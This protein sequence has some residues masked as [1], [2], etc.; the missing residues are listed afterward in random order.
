MYNKHFPSPN[1]ITA[2]HFPGGRGVRIDSHVYTEYEIPP[3]YDSMITKIIATA[4]TREEAIAKMHQALS[5]T[6]IEGIKTTI[7][8]HKTMM[9]NPDFI[10]GD[11][12]TK[13]LDRYNWLEHKV[14]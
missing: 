6:V 4:W 14:D 8:F 9:K 2:L 10:K 13:Y 5:E 3:Y 12:D 11:F 1:K 7:P